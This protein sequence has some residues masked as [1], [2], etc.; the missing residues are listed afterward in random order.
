[1][2]NNLRFESFVALTKDK[3]TKAAK[4][5]QELGLNYV[6]FGRYEDPKT[7]KI[8][9]IVKNDSLEEFKPKAHAK[10]YGSYEYG[11]ESGEDITNIK[12]TTSEFR[13]SRTSN[14]NADL[15][16]YEVKGNMKHTQALTMYTGS[17]YY[18]PIAYMLNKYK[19]EMMNSPEAIADLE[20][21]GSDYENFLP[22]EFTSGD[23]RGAVER[24][25]RIIGDIDDAFD[26]NEMPADATLYTSLKPSRWSLDDFK[27]GSTFKF[28]SFRSTSIDPSAMFTFSYPTAQSKRKDMPEQSVKDI[29][30]LLEIKAKKGDKAIPLMTVSPFNHEAEVLLPREAPIRILSAPKKIKWNINDTIPGNPNRGKEV[31]VVECELVRDI[32]NDNTNGGNKN[33]NT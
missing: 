23:T 25:M 22:D 32:N 13:N 3:S 10:G 8:S 16:E 12:S 15:E 9:H 18:K 26:H 1:M 6:G 4:Q 24:M 27:E 28:K 5:A 14:F 2:N 31:Y 29:D 11:H 30:I 7:G 17:N 33:V 20:K 21:Y 19:P